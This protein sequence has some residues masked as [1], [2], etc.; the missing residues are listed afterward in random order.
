MVPPKNAYLKCRFENVG[1]MASYRIGTLII[2]SSY[3]GL[4]TIDKLK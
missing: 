2:L 1:K 4:L 3:Y